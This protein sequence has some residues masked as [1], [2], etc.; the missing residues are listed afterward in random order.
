MAEWIVDSEASVRLAVFT[1]IFTLV[2]LAEWWAPKRALATS[3]SLRWLNNLALVVV[4]TGVVRLVFPA[5]AVAFAH[6]AATNE[7]GLLHQFELDLW[8]SVLIS[9]VVLDFTIYVQHVAFHYVPILWRLHMVHH[10]D[11]DIDVTT[12]AR[13][14]PVEILLSMVIK[15]GAIYALGAPAVGVLLFEVIL[16][17]MAMFNHGN[18]RLPAAA[19]RVLRMF[20]VTPDMHRV[21]HSVVP[22]ETNSNF[23]FHVPWWDRLFRTYRAQPTAGHQDMRIGL[24]HYQGIAKQW[25]PWMLWLPVV[26]RKGRYGGRWWGSRGGK[27]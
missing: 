16:N 15:V 20:V 8:I 13:F 25:L 11:R 5:G 3:K 18:V 22:S 26:G 23:G 2:A 6:V 17:G 21:H 7:W 19:D 10:A 14:H 27:G 12:G 24:E 9:L 1:C 4:N